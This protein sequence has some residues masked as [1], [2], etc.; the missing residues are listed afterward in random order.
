VRRAL[1]AIAVAIGAA[2]G[3][4][5]REDHPAQTAPVASTSVEA[6]APPLG[7]EERALGLVDDLSR[8]AIADTLPP[9]ARHARALALVKDPASLDALVD[10][11]LADKRFASNVA[12]SLTMREHFA[13]SN[14][15]ISMTLSSKTLGSLAG[16]AKYAGKDRSPS[17]PVYF[18][19]EPCAA[20]EVESVSPWWAPSTEVLVCREAHRPDVSGDGRYR[21]GSRMLDPRQSSVC[22]CGPNLVQCARDPEHLRA[23]RS[24]VQRELADTVAY[25]VDHDEPLSR[26]FSRQDTIRDAT[27][28]MLDRRSQIINGEKVSLADLATWSTGT[29]PRPRHESFPGHHAGILTTPF[30]LFRVDAPRAMVRVFYELMWCQ[31]AAS[32]NVSTETIL[33]MKALDLR[34]G[35]GWKELASMPVCTS[36]HARLDYGVQFFSGFPSPIHGLDFIPARHVKG[37]GP[38]Y[39]A[40]IDDPIGVAELT[41]RGFAERALA[42][43]SFGQCM[44]KN[45]GEHV[46]GG[47]LG[48]DDRTALGDA[49]RTKGTMRSMMREA[50]LRYGR[51][52]LGP[53]SAVVAVAFAA[54]AQGGELALSSGLRAAID[55]HCVDCHDDKSSPVKLSTDKLP[56][57][58]LSSML[59]QIAF[60]GMPKGKPLAEPTRA[61]MITELVA[62]LWP[63]PEERAEPL[64]FHLEGMRALRVHRPFAALQGAQTQVGDTRDLPL[65]AIEES[66]P[67]PLN[68]WTPGYAAIVGTTALTICKASHKTPE[69]LARC[70]D[71][72]TAPATLAADR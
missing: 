1:F 7:P 23:I 33:A 27:A 40:D 2:F 28:E 16:F 20:Q 71:E 49:Y 61:A 25:T 3:G 42:Q 41:P 43:D 53:E 59:S 65:S 56:K 19:R 35:E 10:S 69:E 8:L 60:Y 12:V 70:V 54:P 34:Q 6:P 44:V 18:L 39:A 66:L 64:R 29:T 36:C 51:R 22:G 24:S 11:L 48:S 58:V 45:V 26:I 4:C 9:A 67:A 17:Q 57:A 52:R 13:A 46:F 15:P 68:Q 50:L 32:A 47:T 72:L 38:L 21:C 5:R 37:T 31:A 62:L 55:E 63:K 30:M 14:L